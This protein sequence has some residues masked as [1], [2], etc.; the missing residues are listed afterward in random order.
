M[1]GLPCAKEII[2]NRNHL[3]A[4]TGCMVATILLYPDNPPTYAERDEWL[5]AAEALAVVAAKIEKR[6]A[7]G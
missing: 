3:N 5:K 1:G 4:A 7:G 2:D 6:I